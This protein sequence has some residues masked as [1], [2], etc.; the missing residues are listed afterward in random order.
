[1]VEG[2]ESVLHICM[3]T[4]TSLYHS[5]GNSICISGLIIHLLPCSD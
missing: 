2:L 1:M 3:G 5:R 4:L